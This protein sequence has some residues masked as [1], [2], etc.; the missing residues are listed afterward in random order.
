MNS[1]SP[2][3]SSSRTNPDPPGNQNQLETWRQL[4]ARCGRKA[5]RKR[6]HGLR[7]VT[8]RLQA[9]I[10]YRVNEH[11]LDERHTQLAKRWGKQADRLRE[12]LGP[13]READ[14]WLEKLAGLRANLDKR[15]GYKPR[16]MQDCVSQIEELEDKLQQKRQTWGKRLLAEIDHRKDRIEKLSKR[17]EL[18]LV[19]LIGKCGKDGAGQI[20]E[21][22]ASVASEFPSLNQDNLHAFRKSIKTVRYLAEIFSVSDAEAGHQAAQ[23]KKIQTAIGEWH[24]W[25]DLAKERGSRKK[26]Q[27]LTE[28][29]DALAAESLEKAIEICDSATPQLLKPQLTEREKSA[30]ESKQ[31][32]QRKRSVHSVEAMSAPAHESLA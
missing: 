24:D 1:G 11:G 14:V 19:P 22:F 27:E 4:L 5:T 7:V 16:S 29:L 6:V 13:V 21:L 12:A 8:L 23:L 3:R 2:G 15:E 17:L 30:S 26:H 9:E 28:L 32:T 31:A 18:C 25:Q 10:E 20:A